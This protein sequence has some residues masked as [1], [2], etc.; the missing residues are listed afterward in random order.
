MV[1]EPCTQ[2]AL[3]VAFLQQ[4]AAAGALAPGQLERHLPGLVLELHHLAAL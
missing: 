3:L 2:V 4:L 1:D